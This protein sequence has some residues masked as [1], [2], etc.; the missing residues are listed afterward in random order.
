[1]INCI[2]LDLDG[3]ISDDRWRLPLIDYSMSDPWGA[4]HTVCDEDVLIHADIL[5]T[6]LPLVVITSRPEY[7]R[8]KTE[9]WLARHGIAPFLL[10]M[11]PHGCDWSASVLKP[12]LLWMALRDY[13]LEIE[14][15]YDNDPFVLAGYR[16]LFTKAKLCLIT[17][18]Q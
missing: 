7:V 4:Y 13:D 18:P 9:R 1:M 11:R 2:A 8:T 15:I 10:S 12:R 14:A 5:D 16:T 6:T 3:T 17:N